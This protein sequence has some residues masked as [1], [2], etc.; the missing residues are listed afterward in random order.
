M[1]SDRVFPFWTSFE[2]L[3]NLPPFRWKSINLTRN[4]WDNNHIYICNR[5]TLEI[6]TLDEKLYSKLDK[7][8]EGN[9]SSFRLAELFTRVCVSDGKK[10][11]KN[12]LFI[13]C[14]SMLNDYGNVFHSLFLAAP[15]LS[16]VKWTKNN[17]DRSRLHCI[18]HKTASA[19]YKR[20]DKTHAK[21]RTKLIV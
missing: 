5:K 19:A 11:R 3:R 12:T 10:H 2:P 4:F 14:L 13:I 17:A 6:S 16:T 7:T 18:L 1:G 21:K 15:F 8:P 9:F 20:Q